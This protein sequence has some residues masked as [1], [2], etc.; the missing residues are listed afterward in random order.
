[1]SI[2]Q[3]LSI[4]RQCIYNS[5]VARRSFLQRTVSIKRTLG[6]E[7][8][9]SNKMIALRL[10]MVLLLAGTS[11][12]GLVVP[13]HSQSVTDAYRITQGVSDAQVEFHSYTIKPGEERALA[14]IDGPGKITFFYITDD[15]LFHRTD[16]TGF[17]YP[18]LILRVYWDGNERPSINVPLWEFFGNFNRE[19]INY[20]SL[21]M[22]V[23]HWNNSCYLPMP[24]SKHAR[25]SLFND[26][27]QVY[28]RG[29]A[30]G[31]S[32]EK[33]PTFATETSRLHATWSR[34]N[35]TH[36]IHNILHI[37]G[38]GQYVGNF[39]QMHT[40]YAGWWGEGD[41]IFTVDGHAITHSPGTEDEYG[42][43]WADWQIGL[44]YS[45]AY[46]GNIQMDTGKNRL[47]RFYIPD[48]VRFQKS[49]RVDIQN[50]RAL[51]GKQVDSSDDYTTV[52][53]WYQD[54]AHA[55]PDLPA[56]SIRT[57]PSRGM[58]YPPEAV[59]R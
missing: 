52:A 38:A 4:F 32:F 41:T 20:T 8:S 58:V 45:H 15:S 18:G 43:A 48:P 46:V 6:Y 30:F 26:G 35:P 21:A 3:N 51:Y 14:D 11:A 5:N 31:I 34:S 29:V 23:N 55:A 49:L 47:Y 42:S 13:S 40:N 50:Q 56:Y 36:G 1:M 7:S 9:G 17:A 37:D 2:E 44:L 10:A 54:G 16:T 25:F 22:S 57:A 24:F 12:F 59:M 19:S 33:D 27:D 39:L 28:S 53:F